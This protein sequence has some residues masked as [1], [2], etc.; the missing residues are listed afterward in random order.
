MVHD[1]RVLQLLRDAQRDVHRAA[2]GDAGED[3]LLAREAPRHFLGLGLA[4]VDST[5]S[6]RVR[7]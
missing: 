4:H 3:A 2:G 5:R 6:T 7:S 1:D